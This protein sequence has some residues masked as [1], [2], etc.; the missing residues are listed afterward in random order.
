[1]KAKHYLD[2]LPLMQIM[3]GT[4]PDMTDCISMQEAARRISISKSTLERLLASGRGPET[5]RVGRRRLIRIEHL[6]V[7]LKNQGAVMVGAA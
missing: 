5:F 2:R 7:W 3:N 4:H 6:N 1:M